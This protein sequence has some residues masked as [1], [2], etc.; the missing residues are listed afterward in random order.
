MT[1]IELGFRSMAAPG[2]VSLCAIPFRSSIQNTY[3]SYSNWSHSNWSHSN[4]TY[5]V[6]AFT[7]QGSMLR[8]CWRNCV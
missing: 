4:S 2:R 3:W 6:H 8:L 1:D 7:D 5:Q